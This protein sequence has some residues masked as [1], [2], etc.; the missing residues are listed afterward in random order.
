[1]YRCIDVESIPEE[2]FEDTDSDETTVIGGD[3]DYTDT[4]ESG[5]DYDW[6]EGDEEAL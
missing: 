6:E 4:E 3:D 1:M 5:K 2:Q